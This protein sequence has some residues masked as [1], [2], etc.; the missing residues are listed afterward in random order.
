MESNSASNP[1]AKTT[2]AGRGNRGKKNRGRKGNAQRGNKLI[3]PEFTTDMPYIDSH[4]HID[5]I[6]MK[7]GRTMD[8]YKAMVTTEAIFGKGLESVINVC[9]AP[10]NLYTCDFLAATFPDLMYSAWG[11]HPHDAALYTEELGEEVR[12]R[13]TT[14]PNAVAWG[15]IGLDYFYDSSPRAVQKE[16]FAKQLRLA[17]GT[18]KPVIIHSRDAEEDTYAILRENV[19]ADYP[20]HIHCFTGTPEWGL[21]M[22]AAFPNLYVGLTGSVTFIDRIHSFVRDVDLGRLLLETDGPFMAPAPYRGSL[23]HP[24]MIPTIAAFIAKLRGCPVEEVMT[25]ALENTKKLYKLK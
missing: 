4:V 16:V 18:G 19:P 6:L 9:C 5:N 1:T 12:R 8:E 14:L 20:I 7:A 25:R 17:V 22:V 10:A 23:S 24:G 3:V 15:E 21:K 13:V 11:V 2:T